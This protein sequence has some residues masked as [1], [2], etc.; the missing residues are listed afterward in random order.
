MS[1]CYLSAYYARMHGLSS[2]PRTIIYY[3]YFTV[4]KT[5]TLITRSVRSP[6][7]RKARNWTWEFSPQRMPWTGAQRAAE[8]FSPNMLCTWRFFSSSVP[9]LIFAS[10][11]EL[12]P[13]PTPGFPNHLSKSPSNTNYS[14]KFPQ[15]ARSRCS[16]LLLQTTPYCFQ[17]VFSTP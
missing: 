8:E 2:I 14:N 4:E 12:Y 3:P 16:P 9:F 1:M 6:L 15:T 10:L 7:S 5:G 13:E 17:L 11:P